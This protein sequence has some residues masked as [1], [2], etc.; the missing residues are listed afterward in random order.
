VELTDPILSRFDVLCVV[1]VDYFSEDFSLIGSTSTHGHLF[2]WCHGL[3][4]RFLTEMN[5]TF[6]VLQDI[7]DPVQDEMLAT[8]VVDS[9]FKSHPKHHDSD[10]DPQSIPVTTDEEVILTSFNNLVL[11]LSFCHL[12]SSKKLDL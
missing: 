2:D 10:D 1:K 7:V 6:S 11:F 4:I 5:I 3:F 12:L 8:F 9:H